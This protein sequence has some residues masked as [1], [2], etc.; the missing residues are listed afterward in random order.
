MPSGP[1]I[2]DG[3]YRTRA[4]ATR[5]PRPVWRPGEARGGRLASLRPP[6]HPDVPPARTAATTLTRSEFCYCARS[7][8]KSAQD[9]LAAILGD[10][11]DEAER[12]ALLQ[13][14]GDDVNN[15]INLFLDSD[16]D[17]QIGEP[18]PAWKPV[19]GA[20]CEARYIL[21]VSLLF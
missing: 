16:E 5:G 10:Q 7:H 9:Q 13:R 1:P 8:G 19:E 2:S 3:A 15:A 14:A 17:E 20:R 18:A 4:W 11:L 21:R 6:S 12:R